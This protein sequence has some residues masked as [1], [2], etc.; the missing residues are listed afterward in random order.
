MSSSAQPGTSA[1]VTGVKT[2]RAGGSGTG[3]GAGAAGGAGAGVGAG[4]VTWHAVTSIAAARL[5]TRRNERTMGWIYLEAA[6]ALVV[7]VGLVAWT[8]GARR[9]PDAQKPPDDDKR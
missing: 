6:L 3:D 5:T 7:A 1:K 4:G 9:K 8:F 2:A